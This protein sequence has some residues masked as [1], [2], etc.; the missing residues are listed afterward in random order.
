MTRSGIAISVVG[1]REIPADVHDLLYG[2]LYAEYGVARGDDWLHAA[3]GGVFLLARDV[4]DDSLLGVARLLP[5]AVQ[6][7]AN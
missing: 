2:A 6:D 4:A 5:P 1:V 7:D 3:D